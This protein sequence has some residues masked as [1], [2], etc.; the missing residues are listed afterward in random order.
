MEKL[1]CVSLVEREAFSYSAKIQGAELKNKFLLKSFTALCVSLVREK[2][3][4]CHVTG[5]VV[6][7]VEMWRQL[8]WKHLCKFFQHL[9][10]EEVCKR[11]LQLF[12]YA[13]LFG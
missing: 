9:E 7:K 8:D 5:R 6:W 2:T 1:Y 3:P 12:S 10:I 4:N 11:S 13:D